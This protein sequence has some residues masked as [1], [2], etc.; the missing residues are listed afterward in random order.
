MSLS[1]LKCDMSN[2]EI[3]L[4]NANAQIS[5]KNISKNYTASPK[6]K[7]KSVPKGTHSE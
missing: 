1:V 6:Y 5:K 3:T 2:F 7:K 4:P